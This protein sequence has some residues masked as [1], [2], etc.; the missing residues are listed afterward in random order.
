M[1]SSTDLP[2]MVWNICAWSGKLSEPPLSSKAKPMLRLLFQRLNH[3]PK[4]DYVLC[5]CRSEAK[6]VPNI[7]VA[8]VS[9]TAQCKKTELYADYPQGYYSDGAYTAIPQRRPNPRHSNTNGGHQE[10]QDPQEAYYA[11]L[12]ARLTELSETLHPSHLRAAP[13]NT[14]AY[15]LEWRRSRFWREKILNTTPRMVLLAQLTQESVLCGLGALESLANLET[16]RGKKGKNIGAWAWGLLGRCRGVGQMHSS[17][18]AVLRKL[19]KQ[20]VWSLRRIRAGEM[21]GGAEVEPDVD[22]EEEDEEDGE[23]EDGDAQEE[24]GADLPD[25]VNA[26][27]GY[28]PPI[29]PLTTS[30]PSQIGNSGIHNPP[31]TTS[32]SDTDIARAKQRILDSLDNSQIQ[33]HSPQVP[34]ANNEDASQNPTPTCPVTTTEE[35]MNRKGGGLTRSAAGDEA[36]ADDD[37]EGEDEKATRTVYATLDMLVTVIGELYGQRDLLDGRLLWDEMP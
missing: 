18:V 34:N 14:N 21:I 6:T 27:N 2:A 32:E 10:D 8:P 1:G 30:S 19:G 3:Y 13:G 7:L 28:V 37:D 35:E 25:S 36:A 12:C 26:D 5:A 22:A 33:P 4:A 16:L 17:E 20:A 15:D 24:D 11:S 23:W 29:N 9:P 31:T